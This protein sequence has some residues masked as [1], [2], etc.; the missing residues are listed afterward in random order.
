MK[1]LLLLFFIGI[2]GL[3]AQD[4]TYIQ[5]SSSKVNAFEQVKL[6]DAFEDAFGYD[7]E[8]KLRVKGG[9]RSYDNVRF[10]TQKIWEVSGEIRLR[11]LNSLKL[12][13]YQKPRF[14][15]YGGVYLIS[16]L[17]FRRYLKSHSVLNNLSGK[18]ISISKTF[19]LA[20][21]DEPGAYNRHIDSFNFSDQTNY[22]AD[23]SI[24]DIKYGQQFGGF[25]DMGLKFGL[26]RSKGSFLSE[27]GALQFS[28]ESKKFF[29]Y[30][31]SYS[32]I[33]LGL[34]YPKK[35]S[36]KEYC[37]FLNCYEKVNHLF[38]IDFS[39]MLYMDQYKQ[40]IQTEFVY[41]QKLGRLPVSLSAGISIGIGGYSTY[42]WTQE[43]VEIEDNYGNKAMTVKYEDIQEYKGSLRTVISSEVRY[44]P[45]QTRQVLEG[46]AQEGLHGAY[47]GLFINKKILDSRFDNSKFIKPVWDVPYTMSWGPVAGYQKKIAS[48]YFIDVG[49]RF[50][51]TSSIFFSIGKVNFVPYFKFGYAF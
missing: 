1:K 42:K 51:D 3:Y 45:L 41:E 11:G 5:Y 4:S 35:K 24:A 30:F 9:L 47:L 25:I 46:K 2:Q 44:Y 8:V 32:S 49:T 26:R 50:G 48:K 14:G 43:R 12:D 34:D 37:S 27:Q 17:E 39:G 29:P 28:D 7:K 21:F 31:S 40:N 16:N 33:S 18:Y 23:R 22:S 19:N 6:V 10:N 13:I 15:N 20:K 36:V 38:K